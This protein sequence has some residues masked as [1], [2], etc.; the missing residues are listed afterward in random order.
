MRRETLCLMPLQ[1]QQV[2]LALNQGIDTKTDPKQVVAGKLLVLENGVFSAASA[3]SKRNGYAALSQD[4]EGS[5]TVSAGAALTPYKDELLLFS[6]SKLYSYAESSMKWTDKGAS[7]SCE[8]SALPVI[9]NSYQQ[10]SPDTALHASGLQL[11]AWE[12]SRAGVRYT[13]SDSTTN[14]I[15]VNDTQAS[16]TGQQPKCMSLGNYLLLFFID[17]SNQ[18]LKLISIPVLSPSSPNAAVDVATNV[19]ATFTNYDACILSARVFVAYNT[20][21]GAGGIS[22]RYINTSLTVSAQLLTTAINADGC[23]NIC[24]DSVASTLWVSYYDGT[25]VKAFIVT[26]GL[27]STKVLAPTT[28]ET[29]ANVVNIA[30]VAS[31]G[32]GT[33]YYE[34]S[35]AATY[36]YFIR[37]NTLTSAGVVGSAAQFLRSVGL[38]SKVFTYNSVNYLTVAYSSPLQPTYFVVNTSGV[39]VAKFCPSVGGGLTSRRILPEAAS[40]TSGVFFIASLIKDQLFTQVEATATTA[41]FTQTGVQVSGVDFTSDATF[42]TAEH[43]NNLHINGGI[44]TMYDGVSVIEHGFHLYPEPVTVSTSGAGGSIAAGTYS[45]IATY[46]WTDNQGQIHRSGTSIPVSQV[47]TGATSSNTVVIPTLRLTAKVSPRTPVRLCVYRTAA[48]GTI[49]YL[50]TSVTSPT[51]NDTTVNTVSF[52]D[53][54]A[55]PTGNNLLYTTGGVVDNSAS[56]ACSFVSVFKDRLIALPSDSRKSFWYSKDVVPGS[57]VEFSDLFV[58]AIDPRGGDIVTIV[59]MDDKMI[60]HKASQVMCLVGNGPDSTGAQNDFSEA[61]LITTDG[62]TV[63]PKSVALMPLGLMYKSAK[64]VYLLGRSLAVQYIGADVQAYNSAAVLTATLVADTNQVR[65]GLDTG[66]AIVYDYYF[67]QWSVFT[68]HNAVGAC[69]FEDAFCY[70]NPTGKVFQETAGLFTDDGEFIKL[71]IS[72]SW[73]SLAGLQ[74]FQRIYKFLILGDYKSTHQLRVLMA[75]DFN[76]SNLQ[77]DYIDAGTLLS[78]PVYGADPTYGS[79]TPYGGVSQVYQWRVFTA[80]QACQTIQ[81]TMEDVQNSD[82]GEG[83][84]ITALAFEVGVKKG[85]NKL[86]ATQSFG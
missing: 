46:E 39:I 76:Y 2:S 32:S 25:N 3:I 51:L 43:A 10:T 37:K 9:R 12:D 55:D 41:V 50:V 66:Q 16:A 75:Y 58:Q 31:N 14:E 15:I 33:L 44:L 5:T 63:D 30:G 17:S 38:A 45:Y 59:Q 29:L 42:I 27:S 60:F 77:E 65:F 18:H 19:D 21:D 22:V 69:I 85:L 72:T 40:N 48:S 1:K 28:I 62:G 20:S 35:A 84:S 57:P 61:Q 70:V 86:P 36:N 64:G 6:G 78:S 56:P 80:K 23:I 7:F 54:I 71:K 67:K 34:V 11:T 82:F 24:A 4:I 47:T 73:L 26:Y 74:G 68:N 52:V 53:T 13:V 81:V 8:T 49:Y 79:G 83:Y